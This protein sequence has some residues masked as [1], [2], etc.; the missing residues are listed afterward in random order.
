[1]KFLIDAHLSAR[2]SLWLVD[3]GHDSIHTKLLPRGNRTPDPE[4]IA[5]A[6]RDDRVVVTK[7]SDFAIH[8]LR[9]RRPTRLLVVAVGNLSNADLLVL[10]Q[11]NL[12]AIIMAFDEGACVEVTRFG[13]AVRLSTQ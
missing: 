13:V 8:Q 10:F 11:K 9:F 3:Q 12:S 1:M 7:D 2:L 4:I 5:I 6:D